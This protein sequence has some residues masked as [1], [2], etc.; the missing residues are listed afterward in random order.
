MIVINNLHKILKQ[1][2]G[3]KGLFLVMERRINYIDPELSDETGCCH[4]LLTS[5]A[6]CDEKTKL[7]VWADRNARR[8]N[9]PSNVDV[10]PLFFRRL[11]KLQLFFLYRKLLGSDEMIFI[12]LAGR[13]DLALLDLA[14]KSQIKAG[15]VFMYFHWYRDTVKKR[16]YLARMSKKQPNLV[17]M[18]STE[19]TVRPFADS[20]FS[21]VRV[22]PYPIAL[23]TNLRRAGA[24]FSHLLFAGA[25]RRDKGF[26]H[27][28]RFIEHLAGTKATIPFVLQSSPKSYGKVE[29]EIISDLKRLDSLEYSGLKKIG[30]TLDENQY[31]DI[32][33]GSICIQLY[34]RSD[35]ADRVSGV[36]LDAMNSGSPIV[37]FKGTWMAKF[38][39]TF[40]VGVAV[41]DADPETVLAAVQKIIAGYSYYSSN[42]VKA[43]D[44]LSAENSASHLVSILNSKEETWR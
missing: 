20:G 34:N 18:G 37:A 27:I 30:S 35:F 8:L 38:I 39:D 43:G 12:N 14:S 21:F 28:V 42:S 23:N 36:T 41:D 44:A 4:S 31:R 13:L 19:S 26:D 29:D 6:S 11:R 1:G 2:D 10:K 7:A 16:R 40:D 24:E 32:F 25:A 33:K 17:I 15:K 22:V 5:I 3:F 9:L